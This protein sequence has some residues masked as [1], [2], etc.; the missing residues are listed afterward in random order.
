MGQN[1]LGQR[2]LG[3]TLT[4]SGTSPPASSGWTWGPLSCDA[5]LPQ[6]NPP[7][8]TSLGVWPLRKGPFSL[9]SLDTNSFV[10]GIKI[11]G[12]DWKSVW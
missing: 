3:A 12:L 11:L 4:P 10:H 2:V 9:V 1:S 5:L 7:S 6:L 8:L